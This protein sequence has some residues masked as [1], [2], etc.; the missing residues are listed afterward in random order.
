MP[1]FLFHAL[2]YLIFYPNSLLSQQVFQCCH[3]FGIYSRLVGLL[4]LEID[5]LAVNGHFLRCGDADLDLIALDFQ[6]GDLD[7]IVDNDCLVLLTG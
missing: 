3:A 2:F 1:N 5:F 4:D 7:I 6:D